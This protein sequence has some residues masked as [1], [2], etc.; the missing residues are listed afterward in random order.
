VG[1]VLEDGVT[2]EVERPPRG[3]RGV[4]GVE[5][6]QAHADEQDG[7]PR[8]AQAR[9]VRVGD[10][11][12][13]SDE[14][15][16]CGGEDEP[17]ECEG[18]DPTDR[19]PTGQRDERCDDAPEGPTAVEGG[20]DRSPDPVLEGDGLHVRARVD[21]ADGK[22]VDRQTDDEL[23]RRPRASRRP[24][25]QGEAEGQP[26][27]GAAEPVAR[28]G[29]LGDG[30]GA[31]AAHAGQQDHHEH[32]P[33]EGEF[34]EVE[35]VR[36]D[37]QSGRQRDEEQALDAEGRGNGQSGRAQR[38]GCD[39]DTGGG[40]RRHGLIM[41]LGVTCEVRPGAPSG[42]ATLTPTGV[43]APASRASGTPR[44]GLDRRKAR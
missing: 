22:A 28:A 23:C 19:V 14:G 32:Q 25:H 42:G 11:G 15:R 3:R 44:C 21:G 37:R 35:E 29:S 10:R 4:D 40:R 12:V 24:S 39:R 43:A 17:A 6:D 16:R 5:D 34:V 30:L 1:G 36:E 2:R 38:A 7:A 13:L 8:D 18:T 27:Q 20:Q 26:A 33:G 9:G 41:P 31:D